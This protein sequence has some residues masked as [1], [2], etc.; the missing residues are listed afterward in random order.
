MAEIYTISMPTGMIQFSNVEHCN[1]QWKKLLM[2]GMSL[3]MEVWE[4][5]QKLK[6]RFEGTLTIRGSET[7]FSYIE[8]M[9]QEEQRDLQAYA[10][11]W[12]WAP[13][14]EIKGRNMKDFKKFGD[15]RSHSAE[16]LPTN[17]EFITREL[18]RVRVSF[19]SGEERHIA[20]VFKDELTSIV[21]CA[22]AFLKDR[23]LE[24]NP[25]GV[26]I[27]DDNVAVQSE[28]C[29]IV[30]D[31]LDGLS[32]LRSSV[33]TGTQHPRIRLAFGEKEE[34][35]VRCPYAKQ[36]RELRS[37]CCSSEVDF[38][39][40][41]S[42]CTEWDAEGGK[43]KAFFAKTLDERLILKGIHRNEYNSFLN[44][45]N[46]YFDYMTNVN[47][48]NQSCL[49]RVLGIYQ[50][51]DNVKNLSHLLIVMENLSWHRNFSEQYDLKGIDIK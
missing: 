26:N 6:P 13:F 29:T 39:A 34:Y 3:L 46:A 30:E 40:S 18:K 25:L 41:L 16:Y 5:L 37:R 47:E 21:A 17:I 45:A 4:A 48:E 24:D 38:I 1:A 32:S 2:K 8:E 22:L 28:A 9:L 36:F 7:A 49:A 23:P 12:F 43:S 14:A 27:A 15:I 31:C 20:A 10:E 19:T 50:V 11:G 44:F 42:H 33:T 51:I 35:T